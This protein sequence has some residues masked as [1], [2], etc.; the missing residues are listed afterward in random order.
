MRRPSLARASGYRTVSLSRERSK[1]SVLFDLR[2][3]MMWR[4]VLVEL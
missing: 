3:I 4:L 1:Q 2:M